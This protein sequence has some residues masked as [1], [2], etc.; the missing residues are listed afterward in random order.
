[1]PVSK[2]I[3]VVT[4]TRAEYGLL[5]SLMHEINSCQELELQIVATAMHLS[6]EFGL[7]YQQ[8]EADGFVIDEKIEMLVSG[9][10]AVSITKSMGLGLIGL[11]DALDRLQPDLLLLLGDRTEAMVAA[12]A[13][14]VAKVPIVHLHG[15]EVT[16]GA[17]DESI[18]HAITKMSSLHFV[19]NEQFRQRVIQLGEQPG[20]VIVSGAPGIDNIQRL[21]LLPRDELEKSLDFSLGKTCF[22]VTYHPVTLAQNPASNSMANLFQALDRFPDAQVVITYPN[23]DAEGRQLITQINDYAASQPE[24]VMVS[25]S[26]GQLRYL[27]ALKQVDLVIGNSSSGLIEAPSF[28]TPTINIGDRQKGRLTASSVI[29]CDES[30]DSIVAAIDTGLSAEYRALAQSTANPY[31]DGNAVSTIVRKLQQAVPKSLIR[32]PFYDID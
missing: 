4:G 31:G 14:M 6:P 9:D 25:A 5:C 15:G 3:C 12:Q 13:A 32:K 18:R 11:A 7:T 23:S 28:G 30:T 29:S 24:R 20:R 19:A 16:E 27:S 10:T 2:K 26:L 1:M 21:P 22:L 8:I 17:I